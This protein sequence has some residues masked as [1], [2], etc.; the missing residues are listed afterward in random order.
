MSEYAGEWIALVDI[1]V[2]AHGKV[3]KD[4]YT[5]AYAKAKGKKAPFFLKVPKSLEEMI[6]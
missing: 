2:V 4:V 3:L 1:E 5:E 6:L